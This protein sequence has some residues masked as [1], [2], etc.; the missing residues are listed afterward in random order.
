MSLLGNSW[1]RGC[2]CVHKKRWILA[3]DRV[4]GITLAHYYRSLAIGNWCCDSIYLLDALRG[5]LCQQRERAQMTA[6]GGV[7]F[8]SKAART[9]TTHPNSYHLLKILN[10]GEGVLQPPLDASFYS[11]PSLLQ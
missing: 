9:G 4:A 7:L 5:V 6:S 8:R 11:W 1:L 3:H 10:L 2:G